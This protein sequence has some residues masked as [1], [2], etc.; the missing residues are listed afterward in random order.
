VESQPVSRFQINI[1]RGITQHRGI[2]DKPFT[3]IEKKTG[4]SR[5]KQDK[6]D[7]GSERGHLMQ[8]QPDTLERF[9]KVRLHI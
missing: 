1:L 4:A 8:R 9:L 2:V 7:D 6:G 3:R 5:G